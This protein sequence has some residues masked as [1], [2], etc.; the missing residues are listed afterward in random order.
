MNFPGF[1]VLET[2]PYIIPRGGLDRLSSLIVAVLGLGL[3]ITLILAL[4]FL[5]IGGIKWITS[6]GDKQALAGAKAT[7]TY[8]LVGLII[9]LVSFALLG[10]ISGLFGV[11]LGSGIH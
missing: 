5:L 1:G 6:G 7:I 8:S 4:I 9:V 3:V 10:F 2:E 11:N